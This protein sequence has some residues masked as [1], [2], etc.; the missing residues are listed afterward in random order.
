MRYCATIV[1]LLVL[2]LHAN[3]QRQQQ[4]REVRERV[5]EIDSLIRC[6][7]C[8]TRISDGGLHG[9]IRLGGR[10]TVLGIRFSRVQGGGGSD[11]FWR[12]VDCHD[13]IPVEERWFRCEGEIEFVHRSSS[14]GQQHQITRRHKWVTR[15][16]YYKD[17]EQVAVIRSVCR[18]WRLRP[19][20]NPTRIQT[21]F[22]NNGRVIYRNRTRERR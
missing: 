4:I 10:R 16:V 21:R 13:S 3:A 9:S 12:F 1:F 15:L 20:C 8:E 11:S 17:G 22:Y 18:S 7:D 19:H 6:R 14:T 2:S 5:A